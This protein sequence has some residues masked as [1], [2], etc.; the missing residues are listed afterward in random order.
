MAS[1]N[2][3]ILKPLKN[4]CKKIENE[5]DLV[6]SMDELEKFVIKSAFFQHH[7]LV[8]LFEILSRKPKL[9]KATKSEILN[10]LGSLLHEHTKNIESRLC[11][12]YNFITKNTVSH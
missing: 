3:E 8:E 6:S 1:K 2:D 4:I 5:K 9:T 12:V 11:H 7:V 10:L